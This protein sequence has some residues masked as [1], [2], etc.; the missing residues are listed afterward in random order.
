[1]AAEPSF[2]QWVKEEGGPEAVVAMVEDVK[3]QAD[4]GLLRGF[5]NKDEFLAH[6]ARRGRRSA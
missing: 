6:L 5:T 4:D 1:M 2:E 3:R